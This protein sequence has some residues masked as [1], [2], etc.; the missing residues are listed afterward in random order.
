VRAY[1]T[2]SFQFLILLTTVVFA[3]VYGSLF[4]YAVLPAFIFLLKQKK[5]Y[6]EL[7]ISFFLILILSDSRQPGLAFAENLKNVYIVLLALF[8]FFDNKE[9]VPVNKIYQ[10]FIPFFIISLI[11]IF[12]S[13]SYFS[14]IQKTFSY[15]LV[16]IVVSNMTFKLIRENAQSFLSKL[17]YFGVLILLLGLVFKFTFPHIVILEGR[18]CGIL[19]NP[20]GLGVFCFLFFLL[21]S[22]VNHFYPDLLS[23][24]EKLLAIV[25][26]GISV[27]LCESRS[28]IFSVIIFLLFQYFYRISSF[29][30]FIVFLSSLFVY[31]Y[32]SANI[33]N[34]VSYLGLETYFRFE[35]LDTG[36]GRIIAWD[37]AWQNIQQEMF[38]GKGFSYTEYLYKKNYTFLSMEGHQ[39]NA[40]NSYLTFWLDTGL[41]GLVLY[42]FAF[43]TSFIKAAR[44]SSIAIPAMYAIMFSAFFESWLVGSLN[45]D[46]IQVWMI[47]TLLLSLGEKSVENKNA[48]QVI[49]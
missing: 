28:A 11:C 7:L 15:F 23:R 6:A 37:F 21:F 43:I 14:S 2:E 20:N 18:Y 8:F 41:I 30:G 27:I 13:E 25:A 35:T 39:G 36:S 48:I 24:S 17:I 33:V 49:G 45:P 42:L 5:M 34:I 19:G 47:L 22:V 31:Q 44:N 12:F 9:F 29:L 40:H 32:V 16:L 4:I 38:L 10:V 26:I 1:I 3:G 46:T